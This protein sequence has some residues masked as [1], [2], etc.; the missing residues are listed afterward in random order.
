MPRFDADSCFGRLLDWQR[1]GY[2]LI[3]P[4]DGAMAAERRYLPGTMILE[5]RFRS[6]SAEV[7]LL[8]FFA[9]EP[10]GD[11]AGIMAGSMHVRIVEG[12]RGEMALRANISPRLDCGEIIP[13]MQRHEPGYFTAVGSNAG[14]YIWSDAS[15]Q[16]ADRRDLHGEFQVSAGQRVRFTL[17]CQLPNLMKP[18]ADAGLPDAIGIDECF[19]RTAN[20]WRGWSEKARSASDLDMQTERSMLVLKSLTYEPT[21]A[22]IAAP[23][24]SLPEAIG[25][26]R[27]WDYRFSWVRDSVFAVRALYDLGYQTEAERLLQFIQRSAAGSARQLQI[28][29]AVDGKRRLTEIELDWLEGYRGSRPVRGGNMAAKQSQLDVYG[30]I[31]ELARLWQA[32]GHPIDADYW[33]FLIDVLDTVCERWSEMDYGI[34]EF[35]GGP[36]HYV[37]SKAM[38]WGALE[39]GIVLAQH[40]GHGDGHIEKWRRARDEIRDAIEQ[41]GYDAERGV[42]VRDFDSRHL[43]SSLLLLPRIGFVAHDDPRMVRTADAIRASADDGGLDRHGLLLRYSSP[44][45]LSGQEGSFL[46]CT[47]WLVSCLALQ[48]R[49]ALAWD[50]Y[51][52]A[53]ECA[54]DLGLFSEEVDPASRELLGNFP[55]ALTHVSQIMARLALTRCE[56]NAAAK[57]PV[58]APTQAPSGVT[59]DGTDRGS[60]SIARDSQARDSQAN[61]TSSAN[62]GGIGS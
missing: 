42:F 12:L 19:E 51:R 32:T 57:Q 22:I 33:D 50:Y 45:G 38:C 20:W 47:F 11:R 48:G 10:Q 29:Y 58:Q 59:L 34:W 56:P 26:G 9:M 14:L 55:Q 5:T 43:D 41:R 44:D 7:R 15:L 17:G 35:R 6:E 8:D 28:M 18:R 49:Q 39:H 36:R 1:G 30:E 27:N 31:M 52:R 62:R 54:N 37:H 23:T 40:A 24:T 53:V 61:E 4:A 16:I 25:S 60:E 46:P 3:G 13:M 21:G 2:W